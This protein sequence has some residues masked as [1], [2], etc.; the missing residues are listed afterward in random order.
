MQTAEQAAHAAHQRFQYT[1]HCLLCAR[2]QL[3]K[4]IQEY[5][6]CVQEGRP[7]QLQDA[8]LHQI[9]AQEQAVQHA[10]SESQV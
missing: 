4:R 2:Q 1:Q 3:D 6:T 8:A 9:K 5:D 7:Q 10:A